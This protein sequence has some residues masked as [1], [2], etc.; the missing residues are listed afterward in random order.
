MDIPRGNHFFSRLLVYLSG[1]FIT[2]L[3][4]VFSINSGL[5][6]APVSSLPYVLSLIFD[7]YIGIFIGLLLSLFIF[8]QFLVLRRDFR[9]IQLLQ[10]LSS[11]LYGF[12]VDLARL[13]VGDFFI[14]TY[15]GQLL[16]L[17]ISILLIACGVFLF[18]SANLLPLSGE[19]FAHAVARKYP[20]IPFHRAKMILDCT[21]VTLS[22]LTSLL[23]LGGLYGVREG[24]VL[25]SI[26]VGKLIP[27][28]RRLF[29]PALRAIGVTPVIE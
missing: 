16:M 14:P 26:F 29:T 24:T 8:F 27:H 21:I 13:I 28:V 1:L 18:I 23:F 9:P 5:G 2:A 6:I 25:T 12:F 15:F 17:A 10:I 20:S 11:F 19:A 7:T 22:I 3:G 4:D